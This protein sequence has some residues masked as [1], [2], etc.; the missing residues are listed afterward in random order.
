MQVAVQ[1]EFIFYE[2]RIATNNLTVDSSIIAV[3]IAI[4]HVIVET[5]TFAYPIQVSI[6]RGFSSGVRVMVPVVVPYDISCTVS[7]KKPKQALVWKCIKSRTIEAGLLL[8]RRTSFV[9]LDD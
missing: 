7:C 6:Y 9:Q 1:F 5:G 2:L 8:D 4:P 3:A